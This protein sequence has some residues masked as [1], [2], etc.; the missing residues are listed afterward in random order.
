M[1]TNYYFYTPATNFCEHCGRS[2]EAEETHIGKSS[3]GW[4]FG[5]YIYPQDDINDLDDWIKLF[6]QGIIKD[7]YGN[8]IQPEE[9]RSIIE[10]RSGNIPFDDKT[11]IGM[12]YKDESDFHKRNSSCRGP[13]NLLRRQISFYCQGHGVG[14]W[15]LITGD[16]S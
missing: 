12:G 13:N 15:D 8:M 14:T 1:G 4:T 7:E 9:M 3:M 10:D 11:W 5:L 16:F 6:P 2:D